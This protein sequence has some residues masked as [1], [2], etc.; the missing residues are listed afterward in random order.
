M[1]DKTKLEREIKR[2]LKKDR[3]S[4]AGLKTSLV[5]VAKKLGASKKDLMGVQENLNEDLDQKIIDNGDYI[6]KENFIIQI[7]YTMQMV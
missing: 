6:L 3:W 7:E 4:N 1:F 5:A 2:V